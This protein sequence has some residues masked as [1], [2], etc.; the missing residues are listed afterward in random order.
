MNGRHAGKVGLLE[1]RQAELQQLEREILEVAYLRRANGLDAMRDALRRLG[2][3][4]SPSG[5]LARAP[6][7][8]G[9]GTE[10]DRILLSK[11]EAEHL[12]PLTLWERESTGLD[13]PEISIALGYPLIE[14]EVSRTRLAEI[15]EVAEVGARS[16]RALAHVLGWTSYLV[17]PIVVEGE[18]VGMLHAD[19]SVSGRSMDELDREI[20]TLACTGIGEVFA[21]AVAR[22]A[23]VRHRA[24][25]Q[26]ATTL[27]NARLAALA[28]AAKWSEPLP[29]SSEAGSGMAALT[30]REREILGLISRGQTNGQIASALAVREGTVKYHVKN[31]LRKLGAR[32]RA[33]AVA[34]Y[35]RS[36]EPLR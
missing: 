13:L 36:T 14:Y 15:V 17:A 28:Q 33:D 20:I 12:V 19:A 29:L 22:E 27:L 31:I 35:S 25:L 3:L 8:L 21:Q 10:F 16:P 4:G 18:V 26:A 24:E 2:E 34:R 32:S 1:R 9:L 5:V 6:Q 11:L 7:E 23:L 30:R